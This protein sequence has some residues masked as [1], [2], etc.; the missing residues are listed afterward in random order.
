MD[1]PEIEV[2]L[3]APRRGRY[4]VARP[5]RILT[6]FPI[7]GLEVIL[8]DRTPNLVRVTT[9]RPADRCPGVLR[10]HSA[11]DGLLARIRV[12]GG[13]M[14]PKRWTA[15]AAAARLGDGELHLTSRGNLQVRGL[16]E[17]DSAALHELLA[18]CELAP[19]P[20][21]DRMRN[22]LA[23]P[24][25]GRLRGHHDIG[26]TVAALV[27]E[28]SCRPEL[29]DA[30]LSGKFLFGIDAGRGDVLRHVPDLGAIMCDAATAELVIGG[31]RTGCAVERA[32]LAGVLADLAAAFAARAG[33]DWRL[34][35]DG[36]AIAA[37]GAAAREH[38][39]VQVAAPA[40]A[41]SDAQHGGEPDP[42]GWIDALDGTVSLLA[43][44]E[45]AVIDAR[46]AEFLGALE[47]ETTIS[48]DRVIGIHG[49]TEDQAE[50]VVRVLAP[51]GLI[52]D[53]TS[54]WVRTTACIGAP[55]CAASLAPVQA[56][57]AA[58]VRAGELGEQPTHWVGCDRACGW[59]HRAT[60]M[61]ATG[62]GYTTRRPETGDD[63]A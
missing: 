18:A 15:L 47:T 16:E 37:V 57:V 6:G 30:A 7:G 11:A 5:R 26:D 25:A 12:P 1:V 49:L 24:L 23:S 62:D 48:A 33:H 31:R 36:A 59:D 2:R 13:Q 34:V 55:G 3:A 39:A 35:G 9:Q 63:Q 54:P 56:D 29:S 8:A 46:L 51:M 20:G 27:A 60:L 4:T 19:A 41:A 14:S 43:V 10:L 52:F 21:H 50:Q 22:V 58:A 17:D 40:A 45:R 53:A 61:V 44:T 28:L 32:E 42:V 38:P